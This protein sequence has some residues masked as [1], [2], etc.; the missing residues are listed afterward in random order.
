[1]I[2]RTDS[3]NLAKFHKRQRL[4]AIIIYTTGLCAAA[5]LVYIAVRCMID[6]SKYP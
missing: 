5:L 3:Q 4:Q 6:I 1:M 2:L